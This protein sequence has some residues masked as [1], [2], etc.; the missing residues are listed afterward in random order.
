MFESYLCDCSVRRERSR[1]TGIISCSVCLEEFQTPITCILFRLWKCASQIPFYKTSFQ[2]RR[3]SRETESS[4]NWIGLFWLISASVMTLKS[5]CY[6]QLFQNSGKQN[7]QVY[8]SIIY[9]WRM[10]QKFWQSVEI[11]HAG[12]HRSRSRW[13]L[14][15]LSDKKKKS[16]MVLE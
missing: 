11:M 2:F 15:S 3:F 8:L 13:K 1:N 16:L 12:E 14:L 4:Q 5:V 6:F 7:Q 9:L 10:L